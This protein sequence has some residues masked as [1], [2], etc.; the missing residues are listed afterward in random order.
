MHSAYPMIALARKR[1]ALRA[2][3]RLHR[4]ASVAAAERVLTPLRWIE[5]ALRCAR[6]FR[7]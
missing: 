4:A 1:E 7:G 6:F 5:L 3:I 2:R